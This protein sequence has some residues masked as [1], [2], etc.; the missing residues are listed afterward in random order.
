MFT[1]IPRRSPWHYDNLN[2]GRV[3]IHLPSKRSTSYWWPRRKYRVSAIISNL[4]QINKNYNRRGF[5][6]SRELNGFGEA[7]GLKYIEKR[8]GDS[9][10][11][12]DHG[13]TLSNI[14]TQSRSDSHSN[15]RRRTPITE[16]ARRSC[17]TSKASGKSM[18]AISLKT[19]SC[20]NKTE[21]E[22]VSDSAMDGEHSKDILI[23]RREAERELS[24]LDPPFCK[25]LALPASAQTM[26]NN[27][28]TDI[29]PPGAFL[30][31]SIHERD[32]WNRSRHVNGYNWQ[33]QTVHVLGLGPVG[34]FVAHALAALPEGPHVSLFVHYPSLADDWNDEGQ[35]IRLHKDD[36]IYATTGISIESSLVL[37]NIRHYRTLKHSTNLIEHLVVTTEGC[38][39]IP[40]LL[41]IK[42]RL[43]PTSTICLIHDGLGL[44]E[45]VNT[46][47][48]KDPNT[49][50][51]YILG[52]LSH[53][54]ESSHA[55]R[56]SRFS[57][58]QRSAGK[59]SL[60]WVPHQPIQV[61][62]TLVD[63]PLVRYPHGQRNNASFYSTYLMRVLT[64]S[65]ELDATG[66]KTLEFMN[67]QLERLAINAVI[68][69]LTV[70]FDCVN[71]EILNNYHALQTMKLLLS[72]VS[73]IVQSLPE[74]RA[75]PN[76]EARFGVERLEAITVS[77]LAKTGSNRTT[78]L[79]RVRDGLK[80]DIDYFNGFLIARA[81]ELGVSSPMNE[82]MVSMVK[83]KTAINGRRLRYR[84]PFAKM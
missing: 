41:A 6:A 28:K 38:A 35:L 61:R 7:T 12:E 42:H 24:G 60:S 25:V 21:A 29:D 19:L 66:Y 81:R 55:G 78:M 50:P 62:N 57:V 14:K 11:S 59:L 4:Y 10:T 45:H 51:N 1:R 34:K 65:P 68:G 52:S 46:L 3:A 47:V 82:M 17:L 37:S 79:N 44:I 22:P 58:I 36:K 63:G 70:A 39:T 71:T 49:R 67:S 20:A 73:K 69:P 64:G 8:A 77:I 26:G 32:A 31:K 56:F 80:T 33:Q 48:F 84:I 43:G 23:S 16:E 27:I 54:L 13:Q 18:A 15:K 40:A 74:L 9:L 53:K 75:L 2:V 76:A 5:R 72:E 83:A 30:D